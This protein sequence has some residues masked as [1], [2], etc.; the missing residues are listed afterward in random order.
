MSYQHPFNGVVPGLVEDVTLKRI[1]TEATDGTS[2]IRVAST[3]PADLTPLG[4][5]DDAAW[6]GTD[7]DATVIS[8]LK[9]I[10]NKLN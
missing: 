1:R 6:N 5:T 2:A 3:T 10:V 7:P 9:G 8:L 4:E